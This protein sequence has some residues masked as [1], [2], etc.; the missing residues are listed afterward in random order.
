MPFQAQIILDVSFY[1]HQ[2]LTWQSL[3]EHLGNV[4][5]KYVVE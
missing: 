1:F 3:E 2:D 5:P 4:V